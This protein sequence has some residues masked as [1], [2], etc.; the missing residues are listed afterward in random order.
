MI[1]ID[2]NTLYMTCGDTCYIMRADGK[3]KHVCFGK[4]IEPEDDFK[5]LGGAAAGGFSEVERGDIVVRI[6]GKKADLSFEAVDA[7][8]VEKPS[9]RVLPVL[10]G[11]RTLAVTLMDAANDIELKLYYTPYARGG[12]ARGAVLK[13]V[14][15]KA[16]T[17]ER[18]VLGVPTCGGAV[19]HLYD[20]L[21]VVEAEC[22]AYGLCA[23]YGG[24][25]DALVSADGRLASG[26]AL[27]D[28]IRLG[29]GESYYA[30]DTLA[31]FADNGVGGVV[32]AYHDI[33]REYGIPSSRQG[34]RR[35]IV[36]YCP[37]DD[38]CDADIRV[39]AAAETGADTVAVDLLSD[40]KAAEYAEC[41]HKQGLKFGLRVHIDE[42][43]DEAAA[44]TAVKRLGAEYL[45][46][47]C[48]RLKYYRDAECAYAFYKAICKTAPDVVVDFSSRS[49]ADASVKERLN[50]AA[51]SPIPLS[52]VRNVVSYGFSSPKTAFD[53]ATFGALGYALDPAAL[54]A[55]ARL[56]MRA[57]I[58][59][60]QDDS[61][62]VMSGDVYDIGGG[63]MVVSKDKSKAYAAA[64][65][66]VK[67]VG[68]DE[69]NLYHVREAER[70]FSGAAL[71]FYGMPSADD[72]DTVTYHIRQ[73]ADYE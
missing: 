11:D 9:A 4:R 68:L 65:G 23:L 59:S 32:R 46:L 64:V 49:D 70:T 6:D 1:K 67:F 24:E 15:N 73:V 38:G 60:Y 44:E 58:F 63:I 21:S 52:A 62:V 22:G 43:T 3:L 13:N 51:Q 57:Q 7:E 45:E 26:A 34:R 40:K 50:R 54:S 42:N 47:D 61:S 48:A 55:P 14:S 53:T 17:V 36:V 12:V 2:G 20:G 69:H 8:V 28:G 72:K 19:K 5:L 29:A 39:A 18:F 35:P 66:A 16:V 41:A 71:A 30:P 10:R 33:I 31:V 27:F 56:A 25:H 37:T